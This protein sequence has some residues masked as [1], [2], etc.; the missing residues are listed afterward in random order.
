LTRALYTAVLDLMTQLKTF[1][2]KYRVYIPQKIS[3]NSD[4][5]FH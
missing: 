3:P 1:G 4:S 5:K 2:I